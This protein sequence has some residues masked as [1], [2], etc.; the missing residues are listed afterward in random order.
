LNYNKNASEGVLTGRG[1]PSDYLG[2]SKGVRPQ[3]ASG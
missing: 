2:M 3:N 1:Y